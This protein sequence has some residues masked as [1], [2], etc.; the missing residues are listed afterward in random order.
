MNGLKSTNCVLQLGHGGHLSSNVY[1]SFE[2]KRNYI[3]IFTLG[4]L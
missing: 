1:F 3:D 2:M 4:L